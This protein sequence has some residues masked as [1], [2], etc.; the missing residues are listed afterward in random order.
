M[1]VCVVEAVS[2]LSLCL[3]RPLPLR[4]WSAPLSTGAGSTP[5]SSARTERE[6]KRAKERER[7]QKGQKG[8]ETF[9]LREDNKHQ[10]RSC[11]MVKGQCSSAMGSSSRP[12]EGEAAVPNVVF[13]YELFT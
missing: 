10:S 2:C 1:C 3:P 9:S 5:F 13:K 11:Y 12:P 4:P 8:S 7:A 6:R